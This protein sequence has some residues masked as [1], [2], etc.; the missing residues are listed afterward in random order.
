[1]AGDFTSAQSAKGRRALKRT[2]LLGRLVLFFALLGSALL[3]WFTAHA[4][5]ELQAREERVLVQH[6][7]TR[8][9]E[10]VIGDVTTVTVWDQAYR[11][12]QPGGDLAW[13]DS[14]IGSYYA[15]N[16]G[17]DVTLAI[18][19]HD[20][21]FYGWTADHRVTP[22]SLADF[23]EAAAPLIAKVRAAERLKS[24]TPDLGR[25]DPGFAQTAG[26]LVLWN[27]TY[28][29]A[30]VSNVV[31]ETAAAPR[32]PGTVI[33][34]SAERFDGILKQL[35][36]ELRVHKAS[37]L[38]AALPHDNSIPLVDVHGRT[39]GVLD[40]EPKRPGMA[41]LR[42]AMPLVGLGL[43]AVLLLAV[44][45]AMHV[46]GIA[47]DL[48][49]EELGHQKAMRDLVHAR[50]RAEEANRAKS[51]FLANMSHEI[52]TP[53][54]G[55][56]GMVQV[57]ERSKLG[58][59]HAERL[60]IIRQAGETLLSVLNGILDLSKVEAG[61]FELDIQEF[62]LGDMV[63]AACKPFANL[64]AQKDIDFEI[65]VDA[66]ALGIWRGDAM[67]LRQVL[68]NLTAN[69]VKFTSH[70]GV[71]VR[72]RATAKGLAFTVSD[73]GIGIPSNRVSELFEKFV[74]PIA[75]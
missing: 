17:H 50:D 18:D 47:E 57:M 27:G 40:W 2:M 14:E 15:N 3:L 16:R 23:Q 54:N 33:V 42:T 49:A 45:F 53:L 73:T 66:D 29:V 5:D 21:P 12:F 26:G 20:R 62:D 9:Q 43:L 24:P 41:V 34:V 28:Y 32:R 61:R 11:I 4:V 13:A 36:D 8:F 25:S 69:A 31:P 52:R 38:P 48:E 60:E 70:G 64:A 1:M 59:P 51:Q 22:E 68:S 56:L 67:R 7:L 10:R 35:S 58:E 72:V 37:I 71:R 46:R 39:V 74:R 65:D 44:A 6:T 30:G 63:G 55:I 75:R 19:D